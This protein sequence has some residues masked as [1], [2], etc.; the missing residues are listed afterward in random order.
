MW[1][2]WPLNQGGRPRRPDEVQTTSR[3]ALAVWQR[4]HFDEIWTAVLVAAEHPHHLLQLWRQRS[5]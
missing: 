3:R 1:D 2:A 4:S 5:R